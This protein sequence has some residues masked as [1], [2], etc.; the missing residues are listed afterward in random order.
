MVVMV[1][2]LNV[3]LIQLCSI[4]ALVVVEEALGLLILGEMVAQVQ[5]VD[6]S[7][8]GVQRNLLML[9]V[10]RVQHIIMKTLDTDISIL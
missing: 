5:E 8:V 7:Y 2:H 3:K 4:L 9:L 1:V 6:A 10:Q